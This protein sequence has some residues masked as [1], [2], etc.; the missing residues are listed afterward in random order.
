MSSSKLTSK[1]PLHG[2]EVLLMASLVVSDGRERPNEDHPDL[3]H[4][5]NHYSRRPAR[6]W[7]HGH[8][9]PTIL[10]FQDKFTLFLPE[11]DK[12]TVRSSIVDD[13]GRC[14]VAKRASSPPDEDSDSKVRLP[15]SISRLY[16]SGYALV[17]CG[18]RVGDCTLANHF[19]RL[20]TANPPLLKLI[21]SHS[22]NQYPPFCY[23]RLTIQ[24]SGY[25]CC[26][27]TL[28]RSHDIFVDASGY[29][30]GVIMR[31]RWLAWAVWATISRGI[32]VGIRIL[33]GLS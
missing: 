26:L 1:P 31:R 22:R 20:S 16:L 13:A 14:S 2:D 18:P 24:S 9:Y 4:P 8:I 28:T 33:P 3:L 5:F 7:I 21:S 12:L 32:L 29:G 30:P 23:Y 15:N 27:V 11:V 17:A 19:H 10:S 25:A 6:R